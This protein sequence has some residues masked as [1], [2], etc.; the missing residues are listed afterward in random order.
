LNEKID[1]FPGI[2]H[3]H[4][5]DKIIHSDHKDLIAKTP[6]ALIECGVLLHAKPWSFSLSM[7]AGASMI[8]IKALTKTLL[9]TDI[10]TMWTKTAGTGSPPSQMRACSL[11]GAIQEANPQPPPSGQVS[12]LYLVV[13]LECQEFRGAKRAID[14]LGRNSICARQEAG[15]SHG[16]RPLR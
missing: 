5:F 16:A 2:R 12:M 10:I 4:L 1:S 3:Y 15:A 14:V 8:Y 13:H 7:F 11:P 6:V 9:C